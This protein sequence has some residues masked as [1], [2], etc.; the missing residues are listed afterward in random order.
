MVPV[1][2]QN[3]VREKS[4]HTYY[5]NVFLAAVQPWDKNSPDLPI[6]DM[7]KNFYPDKNMFCQEI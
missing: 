2:P 1:Q 5:P 3:A 7:K 4:L 6:W